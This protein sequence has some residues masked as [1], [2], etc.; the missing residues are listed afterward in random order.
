MKSCK[1]CTGS[2]FVKTDVIECN[3]CNGQTCNK[4]VG[5]CKQLPLETCNNCD[6][7]GYDKNISELVE[8]NHVRT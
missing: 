2:G 8:T 4:C 5:G 6:G 3:F 7:S 1:T